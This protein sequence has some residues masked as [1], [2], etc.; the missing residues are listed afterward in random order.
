MT[1]WDESD[2][3]VQLPP[4]LWHQ[5]VHAAAIVIPLG[6]IVGGALWWQSTKTEPEDVIKV[7]E[8]NK[9]SIQKIE[10]WIDQRGDVAPRDVLAEIRE[11][12]KALSHI[13]E[14]TNGT[15]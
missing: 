12:R 10:A 7:V 15:D 2:G 11:F 4:P 1:E 13:V 6:L 9:T 14:K 8:Q 3:S 5:F